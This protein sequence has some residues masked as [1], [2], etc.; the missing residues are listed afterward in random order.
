M[1]LTVRKSQLAG[2]VLIPASK[3]HTVR[4]VLIAMLADGTSVIHNPLAALDTDAV[5]S[6]ARAFGATV[7]QA[8]GLWKITGVGG[9]VRTPADVI[10]V[11]N[12]GTT[13]YLAMSIA[14][15][16]SGCTTFTGDES[17][18]SRPA[19][20]LIDALCDL[21]ARASSIQ[22][23]GCCPVQICG[24]MT[25]G[26]TSLRAV[27]SQY[28][29]SLLLACPL[30]EG[31]TELTVT[32]LVERPY[33]RMTLDW[34]DSQNIR[35]EADDDLTHFVISGAQSYH[36][37]ERQIPGDFSSA[38]FFLVAAA[39][40]GSELT[41]EG[42]DMNDSQGDK[43]VVN[44]L[45]QMGTEIET[46]EG[47]IR[48]RAQGL[49]GAELD[50]NATPDALPALA[51]AGCMAEGETR[52][53]NVPQ[54]RLK[55]TDRIAL[56]CAELK[57]MGADVE[58]LPDGLVIRKSKL[59]GARVH[60]HSDHRVVMALALAGLCA[61]GETRIDTAESAAVT[62]PNFVELMRAVGAEMMTGRRT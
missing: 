35:Y 10:D 16:G 12:S 9:N 39:V 45:R 5:V 11:L 46:S 37:Y 51:V 25:G 24:P 31:D 56:M 43:A 18:R 53:V 13:L 36:A 29:S 33:V 47:A 26:K 38:T 7:E 23:N 52:L 41:L 15:L 32:E 28:V 49:T 48:I 6:T 1:E 21:G 50:L 57:E 3:S 14:A 44:M 55:E 60:G 30:A 58:E 54:A 8:E 4:A 42:L 19:Q 61:E 20:I 62:F 40:T 59:K 27:T 22:G 34:L 2:R 17:V